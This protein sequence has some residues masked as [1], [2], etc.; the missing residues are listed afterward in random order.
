MRRQVALLAL[1]A[2]LFG[3]AA[4]RRELADGSRIDVAVSFGA[5]STERVAIVVQDD[6]SPLCAIV[7]PSVGVV[8]FRTRIQLSR[9]IGGSAIHAYARCAGVLQHAAAAMSVHVNTLAYRL[10]RIRELLDVDLQDSDARLGL[11]MA[12]KIRHTQRVAPGASRTE[13]RFSFAR[14]LAMLRGKRTIASRSTTA[15]SP[16]GKPFSLANPVI[17]RPVNS[18]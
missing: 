14:Q 11:H 12:V 8:A 3:A 4:H 16:S 1:A 17:G 10:Q 5:R 13:Y 15:A 7:T 2:V 18:S 6:R 9:G